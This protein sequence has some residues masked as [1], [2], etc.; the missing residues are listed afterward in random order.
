[1]IGCKETYI[2]SSG[3]LLPRHIVDV[4]ISTFLQSSILL[5]G[6]EASY[7]ARVAL[8]LQKRDDQMNQQTKDKTQPMYILL[9][10]ASHSNTI[11]KLV[12]NI[13][14]VQEFGG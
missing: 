12:L 4:A 14:W 3:K 9:A 13:C 11:Q 2:S 10:E 7:I 1:M 5:N 6:L 8:K